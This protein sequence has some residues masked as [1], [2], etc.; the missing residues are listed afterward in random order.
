MLALVKFLMHDF[1]LTKLKLLNIWWGG[2]SMPGNEVGDRI[3]NFFGQDNWSQGQHQSQAVDGT[4][5]GLN[6]NPWAGSHRQIGTPLVSNLKNNNVHQPADTERGG[7]SSSVQLG[8]N[9]SHSN[10]GP[11]F[12]TSQ[13]ESQQAPLNGYMH[14]HQVL[15]TRQNEANFLG[16]D[17]ESDRRNI[18]SKGFSMVDSQLGNGPEFLKKNSVRMDFNE[19][20]V[21]YDFFGGQQQISGQHPGMLPPL[22]RQQSGINDMQLLQQQF[23]LKQVQDMQ[24][25]Q[26]Q[27]QK[28]QDARKLNSMNQ[29]SAFSKQ[30][31]GNS[32]A[33]ING[34]PIHETSNFSWHPELMA[35]STHWPQ[36]GVPPVMQGSFR[37]HMF[38]PEQGQATPRLMGMVPQQADQSLYGVPISGT[39]VA[40]SQ[41]SPVQMDK[42]SMQQISGSS[43]SLPN[44]QYT[45]FPEQASVQDG[46][47]VS[48]QGYQGKNT[49]ASSDGHGMNSGFNSES[50][51][52]VNSQQS[53]GPVQEISRM[54]D[55]AGP[56][57]TSQEETAIQVTPSQN[58]ATLDP[59]EAK[60]LFGS[61]DNLWDAFGRGASM[62]SGGYNMMDGTDF[63]S[64]LPSVQ[65]GS[66]SALMQSAV[67]ETSSGDTGLQ[68][69]WSGLSYRNSEPPAGNHQ[70]PTVNDSSKQQSNWADN[71]LQSASS[72]N[73]RPFPVS[74]ETNTG[75][76]YNNIPGFHQSG[77]NIS[78]E[79]SERLQTG[80][81]RH[82][83]QFPGDGTKRS[84]RSLL[85]KAAAEG[86]HFYGKAAHSSDAESNAKSIPGPWAN[87]Q[88]MPSYSSSGQ[89]LS[90]PSGWNF[91]DSASPIT[92]AAL[93]NQRNEKSF[94]DSQ[95][96]DKNSPMFEVMGHGADIWKTTSVSN[97]IAELEHAKSS[98][99]SPLVNQEDT[100]WNNVA[101]LP[102]SSS[103]RANTDNSQQLPKSNNIDIWKHAGLSGN[104]NGAEIQRTYQPH[105]VKNDQTFESSDGAVE[106]HEMQ[107]SNAKENTTDNFH[108]ITHHA[109]TFGVREN[110]WLGANDSSSLSGGKQK[111]SS[112]VGRKPSGVRKFQYHPMGDLD[113]GME[114][115]YGTKHVA[116]S[117]SMPQQLSQGLKGLDQGY[118]GQPNFPS[119]V[120]RDSV[121]IEKGHFSGFQGETK[122]LNEIP[123]KSILP[124]SAPSLSIPFDRS[125]RSPNK[126][127]SR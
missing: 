3:H 116:D 54:Q 13:S 92:A 81:H 35:A 60:I 46:T 69:E 113:V 53:N 9:F 44:N 62:G 48:R 120:A 76:S 57:E 28:Q 19:S 4:W 74:H 88:S 31:A 70:T 21:N 123:P 8:M 14:G 26:Q 108:N 55:L 68:E 17:T 89:P 56:S 105:M 96:A 85:K 104:H 73:S 107:N 39:R 2:L 82:I 40:S 16:V 15:Q 18:P 100:Y 103:E 59:T 112:H 61:D 122:G 12:A 36:R 23:M 127:T 51:Q 121:E 5:N 110:A 49:I 42:P 29:V 125:V 106:T 30:A 47:L 32:Q 58:A 86:S 80:S 11:E 97:S 90:S 119:P 84:D 25:Q 34:I 115:S 83:Q 45:G 124:G 52:Q 75:T 99:R 20:P 24:R 72:L 91:M 87:Q 22:P 111:S 126:T 38:S 101:A 1:L 50:L 10:P 118:I 67:A 37:G 41:Y 78:H 77:V 117:H 109:S 6:S 43:N 71:S 102:D 93:K 66:W 94:Q 27:L 64:T 98:M 7:E 79:H 33:L 95:N 114:P 65:S 63:F